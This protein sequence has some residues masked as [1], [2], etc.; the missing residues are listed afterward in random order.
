MY[1]NIIFPKESLDFI[2]YGGVVI[3]SVLFIIAFL[4]IMRYSAK[5][6]PGLLGLLSYLVVVYVG[7]ELATLALTFIPEI[8]TL[9][10]GSA[11]MFCI[12]RAI[13]MAVFLHLTRLVVLKFSARK[14]DFSLG[15]AMMGG[16]G[17]AISQAIVSG[18]EL[19]YLSTLGN[20]INEYGMDYLLTGMS[21]EDIDSVMQSVEKTISLPAS[22]FL[23]KG[24]NIA[25]DVVFCVAAAVIMYAVIKKGLESYWYAI[26]VGLNV[27]ALVLGFAGDYEV[28]GEYAWMT[29]LK[30][31][32]LAVFAVLVLRVD[33]QYLGGELRS[34]D[35]LK[36][37]SGKMPKVGNTK[38]I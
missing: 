13:L 30:V 9:L 7:T 11:L 18:M 20:T 35:K 37:R 34:F 2:G 24:I 23:L 16:F 15:D 25:V 38:N 1:E 17:M 33:G 21:A 4:L 22:F 36:K 10:F 31:G 12:T 6:M 5:L 3:V 29:M 26:T 8:N 14:N 32:V 28:T 19:I 27:L